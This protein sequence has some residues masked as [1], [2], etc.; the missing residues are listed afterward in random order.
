MELTVH[1][2]KRKVRVRGGHRRARREG[3][4]G[5]QSSEVIVRFCTAYYTTQVLKSQGIS[6]S[7]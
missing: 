1:G 7:C 5:G 6:A 3:V 2:Q 4:I